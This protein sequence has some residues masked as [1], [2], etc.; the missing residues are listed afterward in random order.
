MSK[1]ISNGRNVEVDERGA[2]NA[3]ALKQLG[4][5]YFGVLDET[6]GLP[7]SGSARVASRM[8]TACNKYIAAVAA[9]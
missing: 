8:T 1:Q 7:L 9:V 5:S 2:S 6:F 4:V 3:E